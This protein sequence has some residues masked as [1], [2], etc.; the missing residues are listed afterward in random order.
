MQNLLTLQSDGYFT[1][2][3]LSEINASTLREAASYAWIAVAEMEINPFSLDMQSS[4]VLSTCA[5]LA[6][7]G[8][9]LLSGPIRST[10][11]LATTNYCNIFLRFQGE[12]LMRNIQ[13]ADTIHAF[14]AKCGLSTLQLLFGW[15]HRLGTHMVVLYDIT[16]PETAK[17]NAQAAHVQLSDE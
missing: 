14:A 17:T 12:D 1:H 3:G 5:E 10:S 15:V 11:N 2:V 7:L 16:K 6:P 13:L 8:S 9:G 4:G